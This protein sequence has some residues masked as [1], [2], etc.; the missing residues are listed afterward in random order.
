MRVGAR[1]RPGR[2]LRLGRDP[3]PGD[4]RRDDLG[5]AL[6]PKDGGYLL[7]VKDAV[8]HAEGL[9]LG[10]AVEVDLSIRG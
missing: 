5:D 1:P 8:R 10:D 2:Q 6:F 3:S 4:G 9:G 7:P